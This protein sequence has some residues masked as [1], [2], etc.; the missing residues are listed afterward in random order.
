MCFDLHLKVFFMDF[1]ELEA[2]T[3]CNPSLASCINLN[4][5]K[6]NDYSEERLFIDLTSSGQTG[7][8]E[9][10]EGRPVPEGAEPSQHT[11]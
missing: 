8:P 1:V 2:S 7:L 11:L 3:I 10:Q 9:A 5:T 6:M 4:L